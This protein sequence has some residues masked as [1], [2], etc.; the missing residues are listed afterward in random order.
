MYVE[1][2]HWRLVHKFD[3]IDD[4]YIDD[5]KEIIQF[6]KESNRVNHYG[7][8]INTCDVITIS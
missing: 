6:M 4:Y 8:K 3:G 2:N 5:N 7:K 1:K